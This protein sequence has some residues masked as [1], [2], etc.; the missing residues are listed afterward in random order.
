MDYKVRLV[1]ESDRGCR[2]QSLCLESCIHKR[3][4]GAVKKKK[5]DESGLIVQLEG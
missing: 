4:T 5:S 1:N 2:G 3:A